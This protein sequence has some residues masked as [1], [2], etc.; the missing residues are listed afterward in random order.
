VNR[1]LASPWSQKRFPERLPSIPTWRFSSV[2][3][4]YLR[5]RPPGGS[6]SAWRPAWLI[7]VTLDPRAC[8]RLGAAY[9][10][11]RTLAAPILAILF[12]T[13]DAGSVDQR[14]ACLG[15]PP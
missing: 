7:R 9:A 10:R 8:I 14:V 2:N 5:V 1:V 11:R 15:A 13:A 6:V 12:G 3:A 4:E